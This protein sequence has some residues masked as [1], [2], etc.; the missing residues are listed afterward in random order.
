[1]PGEVPSTV[2]GVPSPLVIR[3][4]YFQGAKIAIICIHVI[5]LIALVALSGFL[6]FDWD[7]VIL[8]VFDD[9]NPEGV[10]FRLPEVKVIIFITILIALSFVLLSLF[11]VIKENVC[12]VTSFA[13]IHVIVAV[14]TLIFLRQVRDTIFAVMYCAVAFELFRHR[15]KEQLSA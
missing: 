11:V 1:M 6:I 8:S 9:K 14:F 7:K 13:I 3:P 4:W 12:G 5:Q 2:T 10:D 15:R